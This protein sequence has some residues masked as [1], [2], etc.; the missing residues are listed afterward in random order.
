MKKQDEIQI[1][2]SLKGHGQGD[3]YFG[4]FFKDEDIDKMCENIK[5]DYPIEMET[6]FNDKAEIMEN[7]IVKERRESNEQLLR[8]AAEILNHINDPMKIYAAIKDVI[9][10]PNILKAKYDNKLDFTKEE[11]DFLYK[12]AKNYF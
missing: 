2:Q 7:R 4:Q 6:M 8:L 9:G 12:K 1:L 11:I 3:T 5:N 10:L